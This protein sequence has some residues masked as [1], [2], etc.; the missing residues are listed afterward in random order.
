MDRT[1]FPGKND[2]Q[3]DKSVLSGS[4]NTNAEYINECIKEV[5][6][7]EDSLTKFRKQIEKNYPQAG[8]YD[9][10]ERFVGEVNESVGRKK[11][12]STSIKNLDYLGK[13]ILLEGSTITAITQHFE[14]M[15]KDEA[16]K[17]LERQKQERKKKE[18]AERKKREEDKRKR[19]E[20]QRRL[21]QIRLEEQK[22]KNV[23]T[24]Q[25]VAIV[26]LFAVAVI[27]VL[28][29]GFSKPSWLPFLG[30]SLIPMGIAYLLLY[31]KARQEYWTDE[32]WNWTKY[33]GITY[34]III[35]IITIVIYW[36]TVLIILGVVV[37]L[38]IIGGIIGKLF[39]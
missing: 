30:I 37:G 5:C 17:E 23:K 16:Q 35:L 24:I 10:C 14:K 6:I 33:I 9:K 26:V 27:F 31:L 25:T 1:S 20:E 29:S 18:E 32:L 36:E 8:F 22:V 13:D 28:S 7:N 11:F 4:A 15:F 39:D 12:T 38:V 34:G 19:L 2:Q 3:A 21:E